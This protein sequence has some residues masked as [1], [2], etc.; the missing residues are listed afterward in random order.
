MHESAQS[1]HGCARS[2]QMSWHESAQS[3]HL[4]TTHVIPCLNNFPRFRKR[5]TFL[6]FY[7]NNCF[8]LLPNWTGSRSCNMLTLA[9]YTSDPSHHLMNVQGL[10]CHNDG[11]RALLDS[12]CSF[13]HGARTC[14]DSNIEGGLV[15]KHVQ[16]LSSIL[17]SNI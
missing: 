14:S 11:I 4:Y 9:I 7:S 3:P 15:H 1:P 5:E 10:N 8:F 6:V 13:F 17:L 2:P 16:P 12:V